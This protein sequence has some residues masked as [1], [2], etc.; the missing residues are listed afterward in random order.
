MKPSSLHPHHIDGYQIEG[1]WAEGGLNTLYL[2]LHPITHEHLLIKT[3][4]PAHQHS[5]QAQASLEKEA[6]ILSLCHHA[7]IATLYAK[8]THKGVPFLVLEFIRGISLRKILKTNP[9]P[10]KRALELF[11]EICQAVGYLHSLTIVHRDLKPENILITDHGQVKLVDFGLAAFCNVDENQESS[12]YEGTP[13]YMSP[14]A[15]QDHSTKTIARDIY[16]LGII[17]YEM[18]TGRICYGKVVL[19][20]L[21][22]GLQQILAKALQQ[23]PE[24]RFSTTVE[25]NDALLEYAQSDTFHKDRQTTDYFFEL[26]ENIEKAQK[27]LLYVLAPKEITSSSLTLSFHIGQYGLYATTL[28]NDDEIGFFAVEFAQKGLEGLL[29]GYACHYLLQAMRKTHTGSLQSL[30]S[31]LAKQLSSEYPLQYT[32][33]CMQQHKLT[34]SCQWGLLIRIQANGEHQILKDTVQPLLTSLHDRIVFMGCTVKQNT[35]DLSALSTLVYETYSL[36]PSQQCNNILQK[37]R[38]QEESTEV[39]HPLCIMAFNVGT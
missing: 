24:Q 16:S 11:S 13:L 19:S 30:L 38:M 15:I 10:L 8:G 22:Q 26:F 4:S 9:L 23:N 1:V 6:H 21:P 35:C 5:V 7:N 32:M 34:V 39:D 37:L 27:K 18:I 20:L 17:A 36:P 28:Q 25:L 31:N 2:A 3:L 33:L 29:A 14:E 12:L